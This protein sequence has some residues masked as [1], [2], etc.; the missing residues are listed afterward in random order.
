MKKT[1]QLLLVL[2]ILLGSTGCVSQPHN[3]EITVTSPDI[4]SLTPV[5]IGSVDVYS[6]EFRIANPTNRTFTNVAVQ[7][8]LDT[9]L[10]Y[11]HPLSKT[12]DIPVLTPR[13]KRIELVSIPE[14]SDLYC[15]YTYTYDV[16]SDP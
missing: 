15:Q 10:T 3:R 2:V 12:I 5:N 9:S 8:N 6:P 7:I 16:V 11:C 13:E 14:F 4:D 1:W